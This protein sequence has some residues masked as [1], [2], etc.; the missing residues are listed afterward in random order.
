MQTLSKPLLKPFPK[1]LAKS[2]QG[3]LCANLTKIFEKERLIES[4]QYWCLNSNHLKTQCFKVVD[5][6]I[7][8]VKSKYSG[9]V[10]T[11]FNISWINLIRLLHSITI[12]HRRQTYILHNFIKITK[13]RLKWSN[14]P[15]F[16]KHLIEPFWH[17]L[18]QDGRVPP[19]WRA[20]PVASYVRERVGGWAPTPPT[21]GPMYSG[22]PPT[23]Y[24][25]YLSRHTHPL[26]P[27]QRT[28]EQIYPSLPTPTLDTWKNITFPQHLWRR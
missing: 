14:E 21:W 27:L 10:Y 9:I 1:T 8:R 19:A 11:I 25:P 18:K 23:T 4:W 28:W 2:V 17:H 12:F 7:L 24:P 13:S 6:S 5:S 26:P 22:Y 20:Y 16:K 3:P 15:F